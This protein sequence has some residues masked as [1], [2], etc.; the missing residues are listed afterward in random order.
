MTSTN[1]PSPCKMEQS[2]NKDKNI[3]TARIWL[4]RYLLNDNNTNEVFTNTNYPNLLSDLTEEH[5]EGD[6]LGIL[7]EA[8]GT[9][10]VSNAFPTRQGPCLLQTCKK[11]Y[12]KNWVVVLRLTFPCHLMLQVSSVNDWFPEMLKRFLEHCSCSQQDNLSISEDRKP[13]PLYHNI[14]P[15]TSAYVGPNI[16]VSI[17]HI[18]T[19]Q[20]G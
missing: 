4:N 9:W 13:E 20:I 1:N 3:V 15:D 17:E 19:S 7:L 18:V 16:T 14:T 5:V 2:G 12:F 11:E 10:L 6:N 8:A